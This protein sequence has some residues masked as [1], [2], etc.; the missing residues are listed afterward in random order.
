MSAVPK[1]SACVRSDPTDSAGVTAASHPPPPPPRTDEAAANAEEA[2]RHPRDGAEGGVGGDLGESDP[3]L[4]PLV[5]GAEEVRL[6]GDEGG[7]AEKGGAEDAAEEAV[8]D[9][10]RKPRAEAR[11]CEGGEGDDGGGDAVVGACG[12]RGSEAGRGAVGPSWT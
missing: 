11:R 1:T 8:V 2:R 6:E 4:D 10:R 5:G 3:P 9:A 7:G 12:E